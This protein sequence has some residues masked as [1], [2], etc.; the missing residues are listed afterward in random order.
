MR[1]HGTAITQV[2]CALMT[3]L[4]TACGSGSRDDASAPNPPPPQTGN[5]GCGAWTDPVPTPALR[6][7][8]N[9]EAWPLEILSWPLDRAYP[10]T[11]YRTRLA[12]KG[13]NYPYRFTLLTAPSGARLHP[14]TGEVAWVAPD[15]ATAPQP[16][17]VE[18]L[19]SA[20]ATLRTTWTVRV[21]T[22]GFFFVSAHGEDSAAAD[23]SRARPWATLAFANNAARNHQPTDIVYVTAGTYPVNMEL[24]ARNQH[25]SPL[26]WLAWP[27]D[28]VVLDAG[29]TVAVG[30]AT[31]PD[32]RVLF[33]GFEWRN[34]TEKMFWLQGTTRNVIWRRNTMHGITSDGANNP[35]F[36]FSEDDG[37]S[38]PI[39]G[40]VQYDRLVVQDN[41]FHGLRNNVQHGAAAVLY[42][43]QNFLFED[44]TVYDIDGRCVGDKDDGYYNTFRHNVLYGCSLGG[45]QLENQY[46]QGQIEVSHN[47]I[48]DIEAAIVL[49]WQPGYLRDVRVH[50]NTIVNGFVRFRWALNDTRSVNFRVHNNLITRTDA[51]TLYDAEEPDAN[52]A[53]DAGKVI[54]DD[55]LLWTTGQQVYSANYGAVRMN[56]AQWQQARRDTNGLL[57]D[58]GL[59][60]SRLPSDSPYYGIYGRDF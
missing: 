28:R 45:I 41:V 42:N 25:R 12:V 58:P 11:C 2:L 47:L 36:I 53:L 5:N 38:R 33:E 46:S 55:N 13:G 22:E 15:T 35:A 18:I 31:R 52:T 48:R 19:D 39:E 1:R 54:I 44:N 40:R 59:V 9:P 21:T 51:G 43:V 57:T 50:H 8:S 30:I 26:V 34:A 3:L 37:A 4:V 32:D 10:G 23:G 7:V 6:Y 16:I 14:H 29:G 20:G 60:D 27:G 49:S 24:G 17:E 56:F